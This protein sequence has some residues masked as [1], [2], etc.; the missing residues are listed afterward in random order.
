MHPLKITLVLLFIL[1]S[2]VPKGYAQSSPH[3]GAEAQVYPAGIILGVRGGVDLGNQQE[4]NVRLVYNITDRQDFGKHDNEEGEGP[5]FGVGYR[6]YLLNKLEGFF[7][8][9]RADLFFLEIDWRDDNPLREGRTDIIVLQPT[10]EV[11]YDLLKNNPAWSLFPT[12]SFGVEINV[13]TDGEPVGEGAI[14]LGGLNVSY[15]F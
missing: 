7:I 6:Y 10:A 12:L 13:D 9:G 14:L 3:L 4:L 5:G 15:G 2:S 11:G 8:G 1:S